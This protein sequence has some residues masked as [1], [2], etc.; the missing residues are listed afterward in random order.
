MAT[1]VKTILKPD[2]YHSPDDKLEATVQ[3]AKHWHDEHQR[4]KASGLVIPMRWNHSKKK[5]EMLPIKQ[6]DFDGQ[7]QNTIG[8]ISNVSL[9]DG[10]TGGIELTMSVTDPIAEGRF[11]RNEVFVSP[12]IWDEPFTDGRGTTLQDFIGCVDAVNY[13]VDQNQGPFKKIAASLVPCRIRLGLSPK[14]Y[15]LSGDSKVADDEGD[16]DKDKPE[17]PPKADENPDLPKGDE[18]KG[19]QQMEAI[20]AHLATAGYVLPADTDD[21]NFKDRLLTSLLTKNAA[22]KTAEPDDE[23]DEDDVKKKPEDVPSPGMMQMSLEKTPYGQYIN[24]QHREKVAADLDLAVTEG[25]MT[26]AKKAELQPLLGVVKLSLD[27]ATNEPI[28]SEVERWIEFSRTVPKYTHFTPEARTRMST[29][30]ELPAE[31]TGGMTQEKVQELAN[32]ALGRK[33]QAAGAK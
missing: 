30:V 29:V 18:A 14:L 20:I 10:G 2:T 8:T 22:D 12:V 16:D 25:R 24:R 9:V 21:S 3:R 11:D 31:M 33:P 7:A 23:P 27:P 19:D 5:E 15:R 6:E 26:P 17:V 1:F 4:A 13:P 32:F 28:P